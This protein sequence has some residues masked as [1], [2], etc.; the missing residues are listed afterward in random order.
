MPGRL[1]AMAKRRGRPRGAMQEMQLDDLDAIHFPLTVM[2]P[3]VDE[4]PAVVSLLDIQHVFFPEFFSRAERAYRRVAYGAS[5]KRPHGDRDQRP[6]ER[7]PRRA[8]GCRARAG[9]RDPP[10]P[11]P[12]HLP[13][14]KRGSGA[15]PPLPGESVAAQEPPAALRGVRA[16]Q[17]R[18]PELRLVLTG[19]GLERLSP[20]KG[21]IVRGR[22]PRD[23]LASLY[24]RASALVFP[25]LY[26]G[27]GQPPLEAMASGCPVACST[28][29]RATGDLW[30][31][32]SLLR[33]DLGRRDGRGRRSTT[34]HRS[35][36]EASAGGGVSWDGRP[37]DEEVTGRLRLDGAS[38]RARAASSG[39]DRP[40][41]NEREQSTAWGP[42]RI[43]APRES[44]KAGGKSRA[45]GDPG[46]RLTVGEP[47]GWRNRDVRG[48]HTQRGP[49]P[50]WVPR[51]AQERNGR[52]G[53]DDELQGPGYA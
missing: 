12:R 10:R 19:T 50:E 37:V 42:V 49:R 41:P 47:S 25:S 6:R 35:W 13:A 3:R 29:G 53:D 31:G 27:F 11:R 24:R 15:V 21:V 48:D 36:S 44:A 46:V 28:G 43:P 1:R 2:L 5:L 51:E 26:E 14:G 20:P 7:D 32:G 38:L 16:A 4:P 40:R 39:K 52:E 33:P 45:S 17:L 22:V 23:H 8:Y 30:P 18:R 34:R 9:R